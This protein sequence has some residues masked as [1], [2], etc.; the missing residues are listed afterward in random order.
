MKLRLTDTGKDART[1]YYLRKLGYRCREDMYTM[2]YDESTK[3]S[4]KHERNPGPFRFVE[5]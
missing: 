1:R 5:A 2:V 4:R 3:R